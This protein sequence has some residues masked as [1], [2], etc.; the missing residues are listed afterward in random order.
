MPTDLGPVFPPTFAGYPRHMAR[1]DFAIWKHWYPTIEPKPLALY[2]DVQVGDGRAP[3]DDAE[4]WAKDLWLRLT[5]KRIDA[6]LLHDDHVHLVELRHNATVNALGRL[7]A[8]RRLLHDDNP[9]DLPIVTELVT[10]FPDPDLPDL[11]RR[12]RIKYTVVHLGAP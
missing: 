8:Y 10:D 1:E 5:R 11:A 2:F 9:F 12:S 3:P 7:L 6:L 4:P